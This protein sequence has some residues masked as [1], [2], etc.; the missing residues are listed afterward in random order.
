ME[1][2]GIEA[3]RAAYIVNSVG[4][5]IIAVLLGFMFYYV[6]KLVDRQSVD[7]SLQSELSKEKEDNKLKEKT[8]ENLNDQMSILIVE[9]LDLADQRNDWALKYKNKGT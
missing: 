3:I 6:K 7:N 9:N 5:L 8:I 2:C 4:I 1:E